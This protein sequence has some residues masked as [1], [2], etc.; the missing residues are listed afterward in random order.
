MMLAEQIVEN[1][2]EEGRFALIKTETPGLSDLAKDMWAYNSYG[3]KDR[4]TGEIVANDIHYLDAIDLKRR[5]EAGEMPEEE[6]VTAQTIGGLGGH[7]D[8][9]SRA[10][11]R[12]AA[13]IYRP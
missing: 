4:E 5:L 10:R 13:H 1:L 9:P 11:A 3:I 6:I 7:F 2:L 8:Q 12:D